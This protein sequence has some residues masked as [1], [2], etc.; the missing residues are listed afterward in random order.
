M[1][2]RILVASRVARGAMSG[3]GLGRVK[4]RRREKLREQ[5]FFE[6]QL[7]SLEFISAVDF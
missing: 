4:T 2:R 6:S 1:K 3:V 5:I 7:G